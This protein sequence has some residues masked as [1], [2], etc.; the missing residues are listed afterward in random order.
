MRTITLLLLTALIAPAQ[1][2]PDFSGAWK[3]NAAKSSFDKQPAPKHLSFVIEHR[4]P[5]LTQ[6]VSHGEPE[7]RQMAP[8]IYVTDGTEGSNTVMGNPLKYTAKW[9]GTT[10]TV[11][12]WGSFGKNEMKLTDQWSLVDEGRTLIILRHYEGQ[13]GPQ[14]QKLVLDRNPAK[15]E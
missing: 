6:F 2:R 1:Q 10:L 12:T 3:L 15:Q 13:G 14:D 5:R 7:G 9:G 8:A 11:I 4:D